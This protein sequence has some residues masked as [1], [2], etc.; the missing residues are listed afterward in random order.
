MYVYSKLLR[1]ERHTQTDTPHTQNTDPN[2]LDESVVDVR[3]L[4]QE[5]AA[6]RTQLMEEKQL[7]VL[8][9][10]TTVTVQ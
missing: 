4:G 5:E 3:S 2:K 10:N 9:T 7:L 8:P 1:R 6:A